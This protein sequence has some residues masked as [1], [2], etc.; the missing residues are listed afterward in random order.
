MTDENHLDDPVRAFDDLRREVSLGLRA[1]QGLTAERQNAPDYSETLHG[2][3]EA[4]QRMAA[5]LRQ[6][7]ESPAMKLTP[8]GLGTDI[9]N[10]SDAAR[11]RD[12][13]LLNAAHRANAQ[14]AAQLRA[15]IQQVE[16]AEVQRRNLLRAA[17]SG[18]VAGIFVWTFVIQPLVLAVMRLL[19]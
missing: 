14:L 19:A 8:H 4:L 5:R 3:H 16:G 2:M 17:G 1:I 13:E 7:A 10:A 11:K 18:A 15:A 6:I 12:E 9:A